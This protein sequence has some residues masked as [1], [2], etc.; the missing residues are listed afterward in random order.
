M[1]ADKT[2]HIAVSEF[3]S[4]VFRTLLNKHYI[5]L[6]CKTSSLWLKYLEGEALKGL[7]AHDLNNNNLRKYQDSVI[8][9]H[10]TYLN[11]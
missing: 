10:K 7:L 8:Q 2:I 9:Y 5:I 4:Y 1:R 6:L 11:I 3:V